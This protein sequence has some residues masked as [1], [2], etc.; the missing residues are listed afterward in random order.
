MHLACTNKHFDIPQIVSSNFI[1]R[2]AELEELKDAF[3]PSSD[4][5]DNKVQKRFVISGLG[6]S[7]K[8]QWCCKFAQ[9]YRKQYAI[10]FW[11]LSPANHDTSFWGVFW[12]SA[13]STI[14]A[15]QS[16]STLAKRYGARE[17]NQAAAID[18]LSNLEVPWLLIIDDAAAD[19]K[20]FHLESLFP[21]GER[22]C[23]LITT[24]DESHRM[25]GTVGSR[26]YLFTVLDNEPA[27]RLLLTTA[28]HPKPWDSATQESANEI[29]NHL[30]RLPLALVYAGRAIL[31]GL[32]TM[33]DYVIYHKTIW[34]RID[35]AQA[36]TDTQLDQ[37]Y[38]NVYSGFEIVY[39]ALKE[40]EDRTAMDA[41]ELLN[42]FAFLSN[43]GIREDILQAAAQNPAK[44]GEPEAEEQAKVCKT[45]SESFKDWIVQKVQL[46]LYPGAPLLPQAL[47]HCGSKPFDIVRL[48]RA[49]RELHKRALIIRNNTGEVYSMHPIIH[50]WVRERPEMVLRAGNNVSQR[51][52]A[53]E[54]IREMRRAHPEMRIGRQ[55]LWCKAAATVLANAILLQP[56]GD[57]S[58]DEDLRRD[59]LPHVEFV[60]ERQKE[61]D[62][63]IRR[64]QKRKWLPS[65]QPVKTPR[66]VLSLAKYSRVYSECGRWPEA[67]AL[68]HEVRD[69]VISKRGPAHP[70]AVRVQ[71]G[72]AGTYWGQ[73]KA[74][75]AAKLLEGAL[76][77][78]LDAYGRDGQ[79]TLKVTDLLGESLWQQGHIIRAGELHERAI[80]GMTRILP[81]GAHHEDT[82]RAIDHL[83]R[84]RFRFEKF[85]DA[86]KLHSK[87][88]ERMKRNE[89]LGPTH[90]DTLTAQD[91]LAICYLMI[92][93]PPNLDEAYKLMADVVEKRKAKLGKE[94]PWT[95]FSILNFARVKYA[96]ASYDEAEADIRGGL[97]VATRNLGE[98]HL[99]TLW[100]QSRLGQLLLCQERLVQAEQVL[101]D[102]ID[103]YLQMP[104][105]RGGA[106]PDRL[107]AM[108]YLVHCYRLQGRF[109]EAIDLC[110]EI[111]T[112]FETINGRQHPLMAELERTREALRDPEDRA[113]SLGNGWMVR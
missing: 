11:S 1:G 108:F 104:N 90:H 92:G 3:F 26:F 51:E 37:E 106:H 72:I 33:K 18:W 96:Q 61:I 22:G 73:G 71:L 12:V 83:G 77:V 80:E 10:H 56:L 19:D 46:L 15:K 17:W 75:D 113:V 67:E 62:Q 95:L 63:Q 93:G 16:F 44:E 30:G 13:S 65:P 82:L 103:N 91:N 54:E 101:D 21:K 70:I 100:G 79:L 41:L 102:A 57:E 2:E 31:Q 50:T 4:D 48:R 8:T 38:M 35:Q 49:L 52:I 112:K 58:S 43:G 88:W 94:H 14:K 53:T 28:E 97:E 66:D 59:L 55:A 105:A 60:R 25:H 47:I 20:T 39:L 36:D 89:H 76:S 107:C 87:A 34:D 29:T 99:G 109:D 42:M 85:D 68:L 23:I 81:N 40:R 24:R 5:H 111:I 98:T 6:G 32:C 64:N 27:T 110:Q 74:S 84:I 69:F 86:R 9:D 7:G 78:C 45:W